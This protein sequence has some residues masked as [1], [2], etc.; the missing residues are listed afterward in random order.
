MN[1]KSIIYVAAAALVGLNSCAP[2]ESNE[3][4]EQPA[5]V[6]EQ[7][8]TETP[9]TP[10]VDFDALDANRADIEALEVEPI[11]VS[12]ENMREKVKQKWSTFH[13]Y[14]QDGSVVKVKTYAHE[15][16]SKRTEEFYADE[17]GLFM[18]VIEDNGEGGKGKAK[19]DIDKIYYFSNGEVVKELKKAEETEYSIKQ[20][21]AEEL[22]AEFNEYL[23]IYANLGGE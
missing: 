17:N 23:E 20:G 22:L 10:A 14:V 12:T 6:E 8:A 7:A 21:D 2:N 19:A 11:V 4:K 15:G 5:A 13:F 1:T 3:V 18:V 9:E 16:I